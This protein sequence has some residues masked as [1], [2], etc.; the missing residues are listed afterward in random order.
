MVQQVKNFARRHGCGLFVFLALS[1]LSL[2]LHRSRVINLIHCQV[3]SG[4]TLF[5]VLL[6]LASFNARKKLPF[7][8]LLQASTWMQIHIYVG[9]FSVVLL[10]IHMEYRMPSG[11][12][13]TT[14]AILFAVVSVSGI[15]GLWISRTFPQ[16]LTWRGENVIF[17]RIP[18]IRFQLKQEIAALAR[19]A[20]MESSSSAIGD[21][22]VTQLKDFFDGPRHVVSHIL[23]SNK[24]RHRL[25][26]SA[27]AIQRY[28]S[29]E[30]CNQLQ[31]IMEL[32]RLKDDLD[33]QY[34]LQGTL[35]CWLFVHIPFTYGLLLLAAFHGLIALAM[36]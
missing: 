13:N 28:L 6:F 3:Y 10:F 29:P 34:A 15:I 25:L 19:K 35:K 20:V 17:E 26:S 9:W 30:E 23:S 31:D 7:L 22:Y 11:P 24:P 27:E 36:T 32:V 1:L 14:L 16:R 2:A 4:L 5:A 12:L 21:F 18:A 8:P 33:H